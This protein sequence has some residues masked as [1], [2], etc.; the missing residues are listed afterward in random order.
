M[1]PHDRS[2]RRSAPSLLRVG[3]LLAVFLVVPGCGD[4]SSGPGDV[5]PPTQIT[6]L[7]VVSA[8]WAGN[9]LTTALTW[10]A[11]DEDG[12]TARDAGD[13]ASEYDFRL[14]LTTIDESNWDSC[15]QVQGEPTP[16]APGSTEMV[17]LQLSGPG[18]VSGITVHMALRSRDEENNWSAISNVVASTDP[19]GGGDTSPPETVEDLAVVSAAWASDVLTTTLS[20]SAPDEDDVSPS[21]EAA[22]E[23]DLRANVTRIDDTNW[24]SSTTVTGEPTPQ[25]PGTAEQMT[26]DLSGAGFTDGTKVYFALKSRDAADNWSSLSNVVFGGSEPRPPILVT[27]P[28]TGSGDGVFVEGDGVATCGNDQRTVTLTNAFAIGDAPVTNDE[29]LAALQWAYEEGHVTVIPDSTVRSTLDGG[30]SELLRMWMDD[31][32]EIEFDAA[33]EEFRLKS[34]YTGNGDHPVIQVTWFG[35]AAYCDWL[36]LHASVAR[37]YTHTGDWAVTAGDP[38]SADGYRLPTEAEWEY[39]AQFDDERAYPW[40]AGPVADCSHAVISGCGHSWTTAVRTKPLGVVNI[41][42]NLVYDLV[43]LVWEWC[44]DWYPGCNLGT[45]AIID[46]VGGT[47]ADISRVLRGASWEGGVPRSATRGNASPSGAR[48]DFGFRVAITQ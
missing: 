3:V 42:G 8:I 5:T 40:G 1:T 48:R 15:L 4:D 38:Y 33:T 11:P 43:G 37:T 26:F 13:P 45:V 7:Q 25:T 21:G 9:I 17:I 24:G 41:D 19:G 44:H 10:T 14:N 28:V 12:G 32:C 39:A 16:K 47:P 30:S 18:L 23:Y 22:V 20:W 36:N 27:V 29:Y 6:D 35:A 34:M 31:Q 2:G 46:P